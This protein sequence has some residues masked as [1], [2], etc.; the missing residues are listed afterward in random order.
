MHAVGPRPE[1]RDRTPVEA[2]DRR[3]APAQRDIEGLVAP[4]R[5]VL[6]GD[7]RIDHGIDGAADRG[8]VAPCRQPHIVFGDAKDLG[9]SSQRLRVVA[10]Q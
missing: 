10:A 9:K 6:F 5:D 4:F 1:E 2:E 8:R 3:H 7:Q